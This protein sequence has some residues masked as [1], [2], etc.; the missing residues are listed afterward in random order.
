MGIPRFCIGLIFFLC[1]NVLGL[2]A[3]GSPQ[4]EQP[5]KVQET[6]ETKESIEVV[7]TG[8][9]GKALQNM[10]V[11]LALPPGLLKEGRLDRQW[12]ERFRDQIPEMARRALEPFGYYDASVSVSEE[13]LDGNVHRLHV[14][15]DPGRPVRIQSV[16]V[17]LK[18][19]GAGEKPLRELV[20]TFPLRQGEVL[21]HQKYE[22]AKGSLRSRALDLGYLDA[23][24]P[25]H[26]VRVSRKESRADIELALETGDRY[27]FGEIRLTGAP[28]YPEL[29]LRRYLGFRPGEVFSYSKIFQ[30][31]LNYGN[32]DRFQ[33]V[34]ILAPKEGAHDNRV[35][36]EVRLTP[37]RP[38]RLRAGVGYSTD[39]GAKLTANYQDLNFRRRGHELHAELNLAERLQGLVARHVW[40]SP[41]DLNSYTSLKLGGQ[42]E[43]TETFENRS[44]TL[45]PEY[46]RGLGRGRIGSVY[47]RMHLED[48]EV[49]D[50]DGRSRLFMPGLR[51]SQRRYDDIIRPRK[52]YRYELETRGTHPVLGSDTD[53]LQ[54]LMNGNVIVPIPYRFFLL[55]R[56]Q[57]GFTLQKDRLADVPPSVRFFAGGDNSVRGY[58]YQSLGPRDASGEV[59]GGRHLLVGSAEIEKRLWKNWGVAAFYDAG[60]AFNTFKGIDLQQGAGLGIRY[61][62]PV[63]PIRLDLAR[64]VGV[65][66]PDF[67]IHL[68]VGFGL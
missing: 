47:F 49:G 10:Q 48:F 68:T 54:F 24:F 57:A 5:G 20:E 63:G 40:P 12:L 61:F 3:Q 35:P 60:N 23:D 18:G 25:I 34:L 51:L 28:E 38:K 43:R 33:E 50:T 1:L 44:I 4:S 62:T 9:E 2:M 66:D 53:F 59:V 16:K 64:Q 42:H 67:R 55:F 31:Q 13:V 32:S 37:S 21:L 65:R 6:K 39:T 46:T 41:K 45:E 11:A 30:S 19:P 14:K 52:G 27:Y 15:V 36:V 29:F 17:E 58:A 7:V 22:T 56:A 8:L 26:V